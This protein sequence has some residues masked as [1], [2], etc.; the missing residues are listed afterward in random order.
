MNIITNILINQSSLVGADFKEAID[1][2]L[3]CAAFDQQVNLVFVDAGINNLINGQTASKLND[4][5]HVDI[6]KGLEFYDIENVY[7]EKESLDKTCLKMDDLMPSVKLITTTEIKELN[8]K[9]HH[10]VVF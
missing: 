9:A 3:V 2:G 7:L 1:L 4:K 6:I 10:L 5:N 8:R